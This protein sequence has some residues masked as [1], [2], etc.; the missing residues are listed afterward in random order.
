MGVPTPVTSL[1]QHLNS[2]GLSD[3]VADIQTV[4]TK[5]TDAKSFC[6]T[7]NSINAENKANN[8]FD[9]T[10][11]SFV[12]TDHTKS[13]AIIRISTRTQ[14]LTPTSRKDILVPIRTTQPRSRTTRRPTVS[15]LDNI[16]IINGITVM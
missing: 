7:L 14:F 16:E 15:E 4:N 1:R 9:L 3:N 5:Y 11:W 13:R 2:I 10:E 12:R 6:V 8:A